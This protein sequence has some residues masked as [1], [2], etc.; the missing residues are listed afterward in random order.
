MS[1][2]VSLL[3]CSVTTPAGSGDLRLSGPGEHFG[4]RRRMASI[5]LPWSPGAERK[6]MLYRELASSEKCSDESTAAVSGRK[7]PFVNRNIPILP[8]ASRP[9]GPATLASRSRPTIGWVD[10]R[11]AATR[12]PDV[13]VVGKDQVSPHDLYLRQGS[14][15]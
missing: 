7:F 5:V 10:D 14:A 4:A 3:S 11:S 13:V 9:R 15:G 1:P 12:F 6:L 2:V 8:S